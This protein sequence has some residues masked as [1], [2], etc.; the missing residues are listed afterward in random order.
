MQV[1][2]LVFLVIGVRQ[3]YRRQP[4]EGELTVGTRISD[5]LALT[6]GLERLRVRLAVAERAQQGKAQRVA[7]HVD[8]TRGDS[9][10]RAEL[11]PQRLGVT[12]LPQVAADVTFAPSLVVA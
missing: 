12:H 1:R 5:R 4:V 6:G 2:R 7:P 8:A 3:K 9:E 11:R 10:E